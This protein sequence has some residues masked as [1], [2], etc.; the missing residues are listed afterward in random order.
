MGRLAGKQQAKGK[1][2]DTW[3]TPPKLI[4]ELGPFKTDPCCPRK[5]P[6]P[7]AEIMYDDFVNGLL[8]PWKGRVWLNPP[9]SR[10]LPWIEL[11]IEHGNG[12]SLT[13]SRSS[14]TAWAQLLMRNVDLIVLPQFRFEFYHA[15]GSPSHGK[16]QPSMLTA[17]GRVNENK[18]YN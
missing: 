4:E 14:E 2:T 3:L 12:I 6:W 5:M 17:V 9:Y 7:T 10:P 15:D 13:G 1:Y 8:Q 16:W 18:L 11:F